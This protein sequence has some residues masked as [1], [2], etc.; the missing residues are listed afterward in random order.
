MHACLPAAFAL[1]LLL[2]APEAFGFCIYNLVKDSNVHVALVAAGAQRPA[3]M[4]GGSVAPGKESCCN[5]KNAECN[6]DRLP[7]LSD[8]ATVSFEAR[9]QASPGGRPPMSCGR[10]SA[11]RRRFPSGFEVIAPLRGSLQFEANPRFNQG[12]PAGA[13]NPQFVVKALT[14]QKN[15]YTVYYCPSTG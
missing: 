14:P 8:T 15:L 4:H 10:R 6:P 5:P 7:E 1:G 13:S 9:I 12:S 11:D 2:A 3:K